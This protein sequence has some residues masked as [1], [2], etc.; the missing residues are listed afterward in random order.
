MFKQRLILNIA[1]LIVIM[2]LVS[3]KLEKHDTTK[4]IINILSPSVIE[5]S[6]FYSGEEISA[7]LYFKDNKALSQ[8][9]VFVSNEFERLILPDV[10]NSTAK[11]FSKVYVKNISGNEVNESVRIKLDENSIS[12][13]YKMTIDCVDES[14]NQAQSVFLNF[15]LKNKKDSIGPD[16]T[17]IT[18]QENSVFTNDSTVLISLLLEDFRSDFSGGFI[19]D[20]NFKVLK[21]SDQSEIFSISQILNKKTPQSYIQTLPLISES[22]EYQIIVSTRDDYNNITEKTRIFKVL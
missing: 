4:P 10:N 9:K 2:A 22:G 18:P 21:I 6:N 7:E 3:C 19:Y 1:C 15:I 17:I 5:V 8:Y 20:I 12:G 13:K 11:L 14:G 16:I